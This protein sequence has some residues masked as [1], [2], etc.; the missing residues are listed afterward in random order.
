MDGWNGCNDCG[1][2]MINQKQAGPSWLT[3]HHGVHSLLGQA[4]SV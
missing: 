4:R 2:K 1:W 3:R